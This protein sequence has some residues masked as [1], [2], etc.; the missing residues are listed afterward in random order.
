MGLQHAS[1]TARPD[2]RVEPGAGVGTVA[3]SDP[4]RTPPETPGI[5]RE[6]FGRRKCPQT[7]AKTR[8]DAATIQ[9]RWLEGR[10]DFAAGDRA[11]VLIDSGLEWC[12]RIDML[13]DESH[14]AVADQ[15]LSSPGMST[16]ETMLREL[17]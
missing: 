17:L 3:W 8:S 5:W 2:D 1:P 14:T 11:Q 7:K 9:R 12:A 4:G 10:N 16:A 15:K 13:A 6:Q